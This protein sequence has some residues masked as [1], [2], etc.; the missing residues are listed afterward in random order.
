[1]A[2]QPHR[3]EQDDPCHQRDHQD[4]I[5][6]ARAEV[7]GEQHVDAADQYD[8]R[9]DESEDRLPARPAA[10]T[11]ERDEVQEGHRHFTWMLSMNWTSASIAGWPRPAH[12]GIDGRLMFSRPSMIVFV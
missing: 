11:C 9:D 7:R 3:R 2:E 5:A 8:D 4:E 10:V 6:Q 1:K 12:A